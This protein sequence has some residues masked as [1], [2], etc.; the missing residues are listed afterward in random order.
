MLFCFDAYFNFSI[1]M[2][3]FW[4]NQFQHTVSRLLLGGIWCKKSTLLLAS[5]L[6]GMWCLA[7]WMPRNVT[8]SMFGLIGNLIRFQGM[9]DYNA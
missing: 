9:W 6:L 2:K 4:I 5:K 7:I 3:H 1:G 8:I